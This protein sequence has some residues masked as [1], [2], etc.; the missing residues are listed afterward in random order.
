MFLECN[1]AKS[2]RLWK[3]FPVLLSACI[4]R[5]AAKQAV[6]LCNTLDKFVLNKNTKCP[7]DDHCHRHCREDLR[8]INVCIEFPMHSW[9]LWRIIGFLSFLA[10]S[11]FFPLL[12]VKPSKNRRKRKEPILKKWPRRKKMTIMT[13]KEEEEAKKPKI[14]QKHKDSLSLILETLAGGGLWQLWR[15]RHNIGSPT[16]SGTN[17]GTGWTVVGEDLSGNQIPSTTSLRGEFCVFLLSFEP[18]VILV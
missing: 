10:P 12:W 14:L 1:S 9:C 3:L 7:I 18:F 11:A 17:C 15:G 5:A 6:R 16:L 13:S 8:I 2:L 4:A